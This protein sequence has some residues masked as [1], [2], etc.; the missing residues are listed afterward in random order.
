MENKSHIETLMTL[1]GYKKVPGTFCIKLRQGANL[2]SGKPPD[3][4]KNINDFKGI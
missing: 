4:L 2:Q 3:H 1:S